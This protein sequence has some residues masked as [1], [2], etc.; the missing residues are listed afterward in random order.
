MLRVIESGQSFQKSLCAGGNDVSSILVPD[1][2]AKAGQCNPQADWVNAVALPTRNV[3]RVTICFHSHQAD[4]S[5]PDISWRARMSSHRM[6]RRVRNKLT[7]LC[8]AK[9]KA[10]CAESQCL[11]AD[12]SRMRAGNVNIM[13]QTILVKRIFS[14]AKLFFFK[15]FTTDREPVAE[16][17]RSQHFRSIDFA[18]LNRMYPTL[19]SGHPIESGCG[20]LTG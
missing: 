2:K 7:G 15:I 11:L 16:P 3:R 8:R 10:C 20:I 4:I 9:V 14:R 17:R 12:I 6:K 13:L 19:F 1:D 18:G 5:W